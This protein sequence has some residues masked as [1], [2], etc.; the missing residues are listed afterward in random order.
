MNPLALPR[1]AI[2][3]ANASTALLPVA[4]FAPPLLPQG[5]CSDTAGGLQVGTIGAAREAIKNDERRLV[6]AVPRSV[7]ETIAQWT[8]TAV[9]T[10]VAPV[11]APG[12]NELLRPRAS[13]WAF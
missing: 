2:P 9:R 1:G 11:D 12:S 13:R 4:F 10:G 5:K 7:R 8:P 3:K 6:P